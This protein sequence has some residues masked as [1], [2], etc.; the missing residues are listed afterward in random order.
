VFE[1]DRGYFHDA[2]GGN[3]NDVVFTFS[4]ASSG[5]GWSKVR[6][7][8]D[9]ATTNVADSDM[10]LSFRDAVGAV[11]MQFHVLDGKAYIMEGINNRVL[12]IGAVDIVPTGYHDFEFWFNETTNK[13]QVYFDGVLT[14]AATGFDDYFNVAAVALTNIRFEGTDICVGMDVYFDNI[15][16]DWVDTGFD[17]WLVGINKGGADGIVGVIE[18]YDYT[19]RVDVTLFPIVLT[20]RKGDEVI[21]VGGTRL[22]KI[23]EVHDKSRYLNI[24]RFTIKETV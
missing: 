8:M 1:D 3:H 17:A 20:F 23:L 14:A 18:M 9:Y 12:Q 21:E 16:V 24:I 15:A 2:D 5:A 11:A 13:V 7:F 19:M 4:E 10:L 22:Y 6:M